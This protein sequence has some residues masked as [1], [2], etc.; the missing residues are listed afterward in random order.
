MFF[1]VLYWIFSELPGTTLSLLSW[2]AMTPLSV[3]PGCPLTP[4]PVKLT[5]AGP[6]GVENVA[7]PE[8]VP[9][10]VGEKVAW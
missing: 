8:N 2:S 3:R 1:L 10:A 4:R 7:L 9:T 5:V 6:P